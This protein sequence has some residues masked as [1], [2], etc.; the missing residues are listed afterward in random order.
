MQPVSPAESEFKEVAHSGGKLT[1][2]VREGASG[3]PLYQLTWSHCRPNTGAIFAV[4]ALPPG[5][6]VEQMTLGGMGSSQPPPSIPGCYPVLIGSDSQGKFGRT[7]PACEGYWRSDLQGRYCPYCGLRGTICDFLTAGQRFYVQQYCSKMDE[8]LSV[9]VGGEYVI[10]MDA[11]ADSASA[12][13][14]DKPDFYYA[15][16]TQQNRYFCEICGGFKDILGRFGY[17]TVCGSR[18]DLQELTSKI[19][20][21]IRR[22]I[23]NGGPYETC[24]KEA[25]SAFDS[26]VGQYVNQLLRLP[27]S[28]SRR[29]RLQK[30]SFQNLG[31]VARELLDTFDIDLLKG[32][33]ASQVDFAKLLFHRRHLYEHKG[34]EVDQKYLDDSGDTSVRIKQAL[35]ETPQSAHEISTIVQKMATNLHNGFHELI[36]VFDKPIQMHCDLRSRRTITA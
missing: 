23:E 4:Y 1:I 33:S 20:P 16:L 12:S 7:C 14:V 27:M 29:N 21:N 2:S 9:N 15:E 18:N 32:L 13:I 36:P 10:D 17:C 28:I 35:R 24:V 19:V 11:V 30:R 34:G 25:V 5:L 8:A 31:M 26:L 22:A 6:V 3:R